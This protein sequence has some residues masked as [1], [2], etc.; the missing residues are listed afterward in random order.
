MTIFSTQEQLKLLEGENEAAVSLVK[1]IKVALDKNVAEDPNFKPHLI[2]GIESW[3]ALREQ[4]ICAQDK[5]NP[6]HVFN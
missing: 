5:E 6:M 3:F 2:E 4:R 1:M